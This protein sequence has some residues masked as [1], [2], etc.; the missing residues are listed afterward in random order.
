M[1]ARRLV[2]ACLGVG[3]MAAGCGEAQSTWKTAAAEAPKDMNSTPLIERSVLFGNPDRA[4]P[5]ISPD[6][7]RIAFLADDGGVLNVWVAPIDDPSAAR[8]VTKDRKRGIR[9][10]RWA[11]DNQHVLY[12][13]D[14]GGDENWHVYATNL[15]TN[16]TRDLTP[17]DGVQARI[18]QTSH[19]IPGE[20]LLGIN[21]RDPTLHDIYRVNL[22]TGNRTL[23]QQNTGF[24]G[25]A[26]DENFDVRLAMRFT[27]TGGSEIHKPAEGG[28][29]T[30]FQS[31]PAA[32]AMSTGP[33]GFDKSGKILYMIDSRGRNT[34]ALTSINLE[35]G[36]QTILGSHAR[37][38]VSGTMTHPTENTI[39]AVSFTYARREW[40]VLDPSIQGDLDYLKTVADGELNVG[41]R[42]VNDRRWIVSYVMDNGPVGYYSYDR[43]AGKAKFLFSNRKALETLP[44]ARMHPE[45]IKSRDG[46]ELVSYL[47]LPVW[48]DTKGNGRP[49]E[50]LPMVLF[51]HGG[52]WGRDNWGLNSYHQWLTNRGY[53]VLSVNFRGSTGLGKDFTNAADGEW[54]GAMHDDLLDAVDWAVEQGVADPKRVAIMGGSYGGYATLVGLTFTPEKFA[55][56]VDIVGPSN[57]ITLMEN[58]PPY[59]M[60]FMS[61]LKT[62]VGDNTTD[63]GRAFL[64]ER[65]PLT[66][67]AKIARP[68]LIGQGANDPRVKQVESDQIVTAMNARN[69]PVTYV[70]FPDEGHGFARPPNRQ[71]F[72]AVTEAFL[73]KHLGGRYEPI[74]DDFDGSSVTVPNGAEGVPGLSAALA[75]KG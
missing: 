42:S 16:T 17:I 34:A 26:T 37:V 72:N 13:Q 11:F 30:L 68:L 69:I 55:C 5:Q 54:A 63:E 47:S 60:P 3:L 53:A 33:A 75:T 65:S 64:K 6:G 74:G 66:H 29:W 70:L 43:D 58:V 19:R 45:I 50:A 38:D 39:E 1:I 51:V 4:S 71:A 18:Q 7:T 73:A 12:I 36:E 41:S 57:L 9:S 52:P 67:V 2:A 62:R 59:W 46:M 32:D 15:A 25:Y 49:T 22:A 48:M 10:Y 61:V 21:D 40:K 35:T 44:L 24:I 23:V 8:P 27:P 20:V 31:I 28:G 56:G 14:K